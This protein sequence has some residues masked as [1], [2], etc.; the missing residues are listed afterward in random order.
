MI[1]F[2]FNMYYHYTTDTLK[3]YISTIKQYLIFQAMVKRSYCNYQLSKSMPI[4][5]MDITA[6]KIY[7]YVDAKIIPTSVRYIISI[8]KELNKKEEN[9]DNSRGDIHRLEG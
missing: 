1:G 4:K 7:G 6:D 8:H 5:F 9:K 3:E 2:V